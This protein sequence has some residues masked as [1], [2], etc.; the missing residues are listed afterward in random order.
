MRHEDGLKAHDPRRL[1]S[2]SNFISSHR[3]R[4]CKL[5]RAPQPRGANHMLSLVSGYCELK[6]APFIMGWCGCPL[7][8]PAVRVFG[9]CRRSSGR[10]RWVFLWRGKKLKNAPPTPSRLRGFLPLLLIVCLLHF[11]SILC[12]CHPSLLNI[13][14]FNLHIFL[15][16]TTFFNFAENPTHARCQGL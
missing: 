12:I 15:I 16:L 14:I 5:C 2:F 8:G 13:C 1:R 6:S 7:D 9:S 3:F 11:F 4:P 10:A